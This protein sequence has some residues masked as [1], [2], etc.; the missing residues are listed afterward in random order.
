VNITRWRAERKEKM[1][2]ALLTPQRTE[3]GWVI[4]LTAEEAETYGIT[5]DS[6]V[7][8]YYDDGAIKTEVLPPLSP[9]LAQ[10]AE[11][12]FQEDLDLFEELKRLGD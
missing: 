12:A 9:E 11:E 7:M 6:K 1:T 3:K 4:E 10:I 5:P 8:L 2:T